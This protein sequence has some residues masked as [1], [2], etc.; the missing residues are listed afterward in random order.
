MTSHVTY[1]SIMVIIE[2][3]HMI[4]SGFGLTLSYL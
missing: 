4:I 2:S 1:N 3:V